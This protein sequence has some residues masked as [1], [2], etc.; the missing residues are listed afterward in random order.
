M[1]YRTGFIINS[2]IRKL[3]RVCGGKVPSEMM[4]LQKLINDYETGFPAVSKSFESTLIDF[5]RGCSFA[6]GNTG[7]KSLKAVY[8]WFSH[9]ITVAIFVLLNGNGAMIVALPFPLGIESYSH[10]T[11]LSFVIIEIH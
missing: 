8:S 9:D 2:D 3:E 7:L 1:K 5:S 11:F 6:V 4:D 10:S